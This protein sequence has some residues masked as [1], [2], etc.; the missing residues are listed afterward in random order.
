MDNNEAINHC[1]LVPLT[2]CTSFEIIF[3]CRQIN[4]QQKKRQGREKWK[5]QGGAKWKRKVKGIGNFKPIDYQSFTFSIKKGT[6]RAKGL[7]GRSLSS[8]PQYEACLGV[9]LL[10]PGRDASPSQCYLPSSM[11]LVPIYT[12]VWRETTWFKVPF[13]RK[14]W[15]GRGLNPWP[16]DPEFEVL[17]ARPHMPPPSP[18][19]AL[20]Y[21]QEQ[22][23]D[24][25]QLGN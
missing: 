6:T 4:G 14:Q 17:T 19:T 9:L 21:Y 16:P 5:K 20:I 22:K 7:N 24:W 13:I 15:E 1:C 3:T 8:F 11:S 2:N 12:P 10:L 18:L 23:P 25:V